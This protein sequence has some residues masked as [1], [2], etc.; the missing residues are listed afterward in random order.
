MLR[1]VASPDS[2]LSSWPSVRSILSP[3]KY[4]DLTNEQRIKR[5]LQKLKLP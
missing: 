4:K 2:K 5:V 1:I 3:T